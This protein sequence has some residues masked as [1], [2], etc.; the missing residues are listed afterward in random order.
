[1]GM[2]DDI[3]C[4]Y[5]LPLPESQGELKGLNWRAEGFQTKDFEC[6]LDAYCI[7]ED[8]S[9]WQQTY[10]W[11]TTGKGRP[12]RKPASWTLTTYTGTVCFY[13]SIYRDKAD[14]WVE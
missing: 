12:C 8:G 7:R 3:M 10:I 6:L 9:L 14:Y 2:F 11:E 5:P 1:M 13:T 4:E